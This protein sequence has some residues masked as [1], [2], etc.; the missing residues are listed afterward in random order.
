[1]ISNQDSVARD[2]AE[3]RGI[4]LELHRI[5]RHCA[6]LHEISRQCV[7]LQDSQ[8]RASKI[9]L[10]LENV[11]PSGPPG[12]L[13]NTVTPLPC[14]IPFTSPKRKQKTKFQRV[15]FSCQDNWKNYVWWSP[16][17]QKSPLGSYILGEMC[18]KVLLWCIYA[19]TFTGEFILCNFGTFSTELLVRKLKTSDK[20]AD[21]IT[22]CILKT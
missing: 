4:V 10:R 20:N 13:P 17:V 7:E 16:N 6:E 18:V 3:S 1:M 12:P 19:H 9:D 2:W 14:S 21:C 11:L 8:L 22:K 15:E 5:A